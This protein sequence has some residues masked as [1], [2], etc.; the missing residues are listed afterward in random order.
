MKEKI[1]NYINIAKK[2]N[3]VIIGLKKV[4]SSCNNDK[5]KLVI[6]SKDTRLK[7][8]N[9][10]KAKHKDIYFYDGFSS[11]EISRI[12]GVNNLKVIALLSFGISNAIIKNIEGG[13]FEKK[14][15]L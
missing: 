7:E 10:L 11:D 6:Y 5:T 4:V 9:F 13:I 2:Q 3:G 8:I 12:M 15:S 14:K 1:I